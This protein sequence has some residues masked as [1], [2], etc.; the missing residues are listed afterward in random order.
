[1]SDS[2][3][4]HEKDFVQKRELVDISTK[5]TETEVENQKLQKE[6][7]RLTKENELFRKALAEVE[8]EKAILAYNQLGSS[9]KIRMLLQDGTAAVVG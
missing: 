7:E 6:I 4:K 3:P 2:L 5:L 9:V 1:M 8:V